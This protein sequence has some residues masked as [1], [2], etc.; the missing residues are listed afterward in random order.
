MA[1]NPIIEVRGL[2]KHFEA[3]QHLFR[4]SS[5]GAGVLKAVDDVSFRIPKGHSR[6]CWREWLR[7][8]D[9]RQNAAEAV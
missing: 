3:R 7:K 8:D 5:T 4:K 2:S 6:N 9:D 1:E